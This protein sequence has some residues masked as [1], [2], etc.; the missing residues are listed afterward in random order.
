MVLIGDV[1][2]LLYLFLLFLIVAIFFLCYLWSELLFFMFLLFF[3]LFFNDYLVSGIFEDVDCWHPE[4][5]KQEVMFPE[6]DSYEPTIEGALPTN[7]IC[8]IFINGTCRLES[9]DISDLA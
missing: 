2:S 7:N 8:S 4:I 6:P 3:M 1:C 5:L 9:M